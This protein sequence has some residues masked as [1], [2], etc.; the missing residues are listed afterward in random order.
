M[1]CF[2][3]GGSNFSTDGSAQLAKDQQLGIYNKEYIKE[4]IY[5]SHFGILLLY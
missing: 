4:F 3:E 1:L 5:I 2:A